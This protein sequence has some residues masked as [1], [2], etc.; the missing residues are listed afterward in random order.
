MSNLKQNR[1]VI[2]QSCD[3][4]ARNVVSLKAG[5]FG[6]LAYPLANVLAIWNA[7]AV[8][9]HHMHNRIANISFTDLLSI[10]TSPSL[11]Q[12]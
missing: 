1:N 9:G 3:H 4:C 7:K 11:P 12:F 2:K 10:I 6:A 8:Q 5:H